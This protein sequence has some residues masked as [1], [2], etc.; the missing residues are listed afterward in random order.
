MTSSE[1]KELALYLTDALSYWKADVSQFTLQVWI[2][3][4]DGFTL[5]QVKKAIVQHATDPD[6]GQFAPKVADIV[7]QLVGTKTDMSLRA[8][9]KVH[10]AMSDVGAYSSVVFD[11]P[12]I[13]RVIEDLGGWPKLCRTPVD[14]L[15]YVQH[16]FCEAY[17]AYAGRGDFEY[18][19]CLIGDH[20]DAGAY[21][22]RGLPPPKP[23]PIGDREAALLVYRQGQKSSPSALILQAAR[24]ALKD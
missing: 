18:P 23:V 17:R 19:P 6:R 20:A 7:R 13:H 12:V 16:R 15:S 2:S 24:L 1:R 14:D 21:A 22:K 9:S 8:W 5:E 3:A 11:D 10:S 4:C